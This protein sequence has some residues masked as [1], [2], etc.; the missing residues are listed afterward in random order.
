MASK[1]LHVHDH[2]LKNQGAAA[3]ADVIEDQ[4]LRKSNC[5]GAAETDVIEEQ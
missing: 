1:L 4:Q 2:K 3:E 5:G